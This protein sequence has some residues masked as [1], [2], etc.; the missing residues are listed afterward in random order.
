[1]MTILMTGGIGGC[2]KYISAKGELDKSFG[3]GGIVVDNNAA[4]G[5]SDDIGNSIYVDS[6]GKIYVTG[7]SVNRSFNFDMVIWMYR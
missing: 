2:S 6:K 5:N 3:E 1:M 4:G 7:F